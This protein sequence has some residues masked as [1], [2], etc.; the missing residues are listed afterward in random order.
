MDSP[1]TV[2]PDAGEPCLPV[3]LADEDLPA[4]WG[5]ALDSSQQDREQLGGGEV[6]L[7]EIADVVGSDPDVLREFVRTH[8]PTHRYLVTH[9]LSTTVWAG[10]YMAVDMRTK[11]PTVLKISRRSIE[12]EGSLSATINHPNVVTVHDVFVHAGYPTAALEWCQQGTLRVYANGCGWRDTLARAIE[13]GRGLAHLHERGLVHADI[14]PSNILINH[15]IGKVGD[16]G[17]AGPETMHGPTWGTIEYLPPE[18]SR[19]VFT[20]AGDVYSFALTIEHSLRRHADVPPSIGRVL[21][22]ALVTDYQRR[23]TLAGLLA[24]LQQELDN[25]R[26]EQARRGLE[27]RRQRTL[28]QTA[29]MFALLACAGGA[30]AIAATCADS[31]ERER[32]EPTVEQTLDHAVDAADRGE[33]VAAVQLLELAMRRAKLT[34]DPEALQRVAG[35]AESLGHRFDAAGDRVTAVRCWLVAHD[36]FLELDDDMGQARV[37]RFGTE[38]VP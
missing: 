2:S 34:G 25:D 35:V 7:D 23:P 30:V 21:D 4:W 11:R 8:P 29:A 17:L 14:K 19:G 26:L 9:P 6:D 27:Q 31:F 15:E 24:E 36:C 10:V 5:P 37:L 28:L 13:A 32:A 1:A 22:A 33:A 16:L 38:T 20:F 12:L 3:P 18:R